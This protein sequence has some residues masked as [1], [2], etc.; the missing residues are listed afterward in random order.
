MNA[1]IAKLLKVLMPEAGR[2]AWKDCARHDSPVST[3]TKRISLREI[4]DSLIVE[5]VCGRDRGAANRT[6][7]IA[8]ADISRPAR[9]EI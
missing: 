1:E 4:V 6:T 2:A 7:E 5:N 8:V 9:T 3:R